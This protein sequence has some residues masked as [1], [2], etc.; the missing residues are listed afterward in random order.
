MLDLRVIAAVLGG[1]VSG[2]QVLCPGPGH[3]PAD[4]SLAVRPARSMP[5]GIVVYSHCGDPWRECR[6][7]VLGLL[8]R[9]PYEPPH[10]AP[11]PPPRSTQSWALQIW[12]DSVDPHGTLA[13][14][15]LASRKLELPDDAARFIRFHAA[16]PWT[17]DRDVRVR[18]PALVAL[19]RTIGGDEPSAIQRTALR[20]DASKIG[21]KMLGPV[22]GCA[23]K[24]TCDEDVLFRLGVA[25]G[26]ESAMSANALG[27]GPS[28]ALGSAGAIRNLPVLPGIETLALIAEHDR[29][30]EEAREVCAARWYDAAREVLIVEPANHACKDLN[31]VLRRVAR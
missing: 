27:Q 28:W 29:A 20:G 31:D 17:D 16:C 30:N 7:H 18:V 13:E 23:I 4:R 10:R 22:G 1:E 15:Y 21:R 9:A 8:G 12:G 11:R 19:F 14:R 25:E 6:D 24:V 2:G 5:D 26:L 3:S